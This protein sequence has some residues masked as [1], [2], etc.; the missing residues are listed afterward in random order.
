MIAKALRSRLDGLDRP[1][2]LLNG[3]LG[4]V[5]LGCMAAFAYFVFS[6]MPRMGEDLPAGTQ[7]LQSA[8]PCV[9]S[10]LRPLSD[11]GTVVTSKAFNDATQAC[12][13]IDQA[14][15]LSN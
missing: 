14:K 3:L 11:A 5:I 1:A 12:L 15:A 8:S 10:K 13:V 9:K 6:T 7:G 2:L 4:L